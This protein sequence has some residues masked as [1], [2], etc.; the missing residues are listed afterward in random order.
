M[1]QAT[2]GAVYVF[3]NISTPR[4][5]KIGTTAGS[6]LAR[7]RALSRTSAVAT[8]FRVL[9]YYEVDDAV[10]GELLIHRSLAGRRVRRRR[11][12]FWVGKDELSDL[13]DLM[14]IMLT[15]VAADPQP[16]TV[17]RDDLSSEESIVWLED[18]SSLPYVQNQ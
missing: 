2:P 16:K 15:S 9:F 13:Q 10:F 3:G 8:P 11:E 4:Q 18:P 17:H 1:K 14:T 5:V 6:V 12:F 7:N